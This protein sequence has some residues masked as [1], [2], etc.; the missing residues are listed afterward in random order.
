MVPVLELLIHPAPRLPAA[1]VSQ[2]GVVAIAFPLA[3]GSKVQKTSLQ[4]PFTVPSCDRLAGVD[5]M[6]VLTT[7]KGVTIDRNRNRV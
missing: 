5:C 4:H 3:P 6:R 1:L 2:C 7:S